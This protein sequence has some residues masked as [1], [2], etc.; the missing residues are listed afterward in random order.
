MVSHTA[1][2]CSSQRGPLTKHKASLYQHRGTTPAFVHLQLSDRKGDA[3]KGGSP[4]PA[5]L[6]WI[7]LAL[8]Q[9]EGE[10]GSAWAPG[11]GSCLGSGKEGA[12]HSCKGHGAAASAAPPLYCACGSPVPAGS[13]HR[14]VPISRV[15]S[16]TCRDSGVM[17]ALAAQAGS[18]SSGDAVSCPRSPPFPLFGGVL[19]PFLHPPR[20]LYPPGK[21]PAARMAMGRRER[22]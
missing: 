18:S 13:I 20:M 11:V 12:G 10:S 19:P 6:P 2:V 15:S 17:V 21:G 22:V 5:P 16:A 4:S 7:R 3:E 14:D 1:M 8:E 9:R